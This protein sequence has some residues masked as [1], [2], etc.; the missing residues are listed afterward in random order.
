MTISIM[1]YLLYPPISSSMAYL[2]ALWTCIGTS[3]S[4]TGN[5]LGFTPCVRIKRV[6]IFTIQVLA[7]VFFQTQL[8]SVLILFSAALVFL[9]YP[10]SLFFLVVPMFYCRSPSTH[11]PAPLPTHSH[12]LV[13]AF[14]CTGAYNVCKTKGPLFPMMA[15][16]AI[17]CYICS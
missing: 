6:V 7:R 13:L 1:L 16:C 9:P 14:P 10:Y 2:I 4:I 3:L 12:F 8:S 17:F 15:D 11:A 5:S